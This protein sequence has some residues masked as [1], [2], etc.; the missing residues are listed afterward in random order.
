MRLDAG[1]KSELKRGGRK[2][3][4]GNFLTPTVPVGAVPK[5]NNVTDRHA[6]QPCYPTSANP[7]SYPATVRKPQRTGET[8]LHTITVVSVNSV[9]YLPWG[10][11]MKD[12]SANTLEIQILST[13]N[14]VKAL[15]G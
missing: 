8:L 14:N 2:V 5:L 7:K 1:S 15:S 12:M 6:K 11:F 10:D 4:W 13:A 3:H 9:V